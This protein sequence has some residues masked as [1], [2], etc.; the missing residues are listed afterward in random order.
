[1]ETKQAYSGPV[2]RGVRNFP[3]GA[4][5]INSG[6]TA[7]APSN[8]PGNNHATPQNA[9]A[10]QPSP[11]GGN[12]N[13]MGGLKRYFGRDL[14]NLEETGTGPLNAGDNKSHFKNS[15]RENTAGSQPKKSRP[16]PIAFFKGLFEN[17][18]HKLL[19][20][21]DGLMTDPDDTP[22]D[23]PCNRRLHHSRERSLASQ[24]NPQSQGVQMGEVSNQNF[25]PQNLPNSSV[26]LSKPALRL[27]SHQAHNSEITMAP[28]FKA[29]QSK[30]Q[31]MPLV[32]SRRRDSKELS[33]SNQVGPCVNRGEITNSHHQLAHNF[34]GVNGASSENIAGDYLSKLK[35]QSSIQTSDL[36]NTQSGA[37]NTDHGYPTMQGLN[38][39][40]GQGSKISGLICSSIQAIAKKSGSK[41]SGIC[42]QEAGQLG[43]G[44]KASQYPATVYSQNKG[45]FLCSVATQEPA[46]GDQQGKP[47]QKQQ[48]NPEPVLIPIVQVPQPQASLL[49][50]NSSIASRARRSFLNPKFKHLCLQIESGT[51]PT[52]VML[53]EAIHPNPDVQQS[54]ANG[55]MMV[56]NTTSCGF[57]GG[58]HAPGGPAAQMM[59]EPLPSPDGVKPSLMK[60]ELIRSR[61]PVAVASKA[62]GL[63]L[64]AIWNH[65]LTN[66]VVFVDYQE[67]KWLFERIFLQASVA[68]GKHEEDLGGLAGRCPQEIQVAA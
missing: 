67:T 46:L 6:R 54:A 53:E 19:K 33:A 61:S 9:I 52:D 62:S 48:S 68:N 2:A 37:F 3:N 17:Q 34:I 39:T 8:I 66:E 44:R 15:N 55:A 27:M 58:R 49:R 4:P 43:E 42:I 7:I 21:R 24:M 45:S 35:K 51:G 14:T 59:Q 20:R 31:V 29:D 26:V 47:E 16:S 22:A 64:E 32:R 57:V 12:R 40:R 10:P 65:L 11:L 25:H 28:N 50:S 23:L 1:M 13:N 5:M 30:Q 63:D 60:Q 56:E 36:M 38:S 41:N 18:K